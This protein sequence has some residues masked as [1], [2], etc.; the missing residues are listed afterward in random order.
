MRY[1]SYVFIVLLMSNLSHVALAITLNVAL[2]VHAQIDI[3][4]SKAPPLALPIAVMNIFDTNTV[5][6]YSLLVQPDGVILLWQRLY[7]DRP[8]STEPFDGFIRPEMHWSIPT[9]TSNP[10]AIQL[11]P[12]RIEELV[13]T[14]SQ[15]FITVKQRVY[16]YSFEH[17]NIIFSHGSFL[18]QDFIGLNAVVDIQASGLISPSQFGQLPAEIQSQYGMAFGSAS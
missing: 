15:L 7:D 11:T 3:Q 14:V 8:I 6:R 13:G 17:N 10:V 18:K 2:A 9:Q 1:L 16:A 5:A 12:Q 4:I